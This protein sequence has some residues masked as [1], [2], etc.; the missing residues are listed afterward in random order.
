VDVSVSLRGTWCWDCVRQTIS[1]PSVTWLA[2]FIGI[3]SKR[4]EIWGGVK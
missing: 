3:E 4:G 2:W 1:H